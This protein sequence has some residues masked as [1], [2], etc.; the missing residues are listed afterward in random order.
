[1]AEK[2]DI[3]CYHCGDIC[4][5]DSISKEDKY[6]CCNGCL[7]VYELLSQ[8]EMKDYYSMVDIKGLAPKEVKAS[9]FEFLDD[10]KVIES[11]IQYSLAGKSKVI[12]Y[13]PEIYCSACIWLLENLYRLNKGITESEVN[14]LKKELTVVFEE[15]DTGLR[16][17]VELL[18]SIGYRPKLNLSDLDKPKKDIVDR[19]LY[20]KLGIAGFC[21]GNIMLFAF[22]EYLSGGMYD[23]SIKKFI[24]WIN[25][26]L[27][28]PA[29]YAG[30]SYFKSAWAGL[31]ARHI[32]I[33]VP[34]SLGIITLFIRSAYEIISGTGAGFID[35]MSGL[36]FFLLIGKVFQQKTYYNMSFG[37]DYKS[38]FPLSV[39]LKK[40]GG[41]TH[42]SVKNIE[43]G[44]TI[45]IRNNEIIPADSRLLSDSASIDYS[46]VTGESEPVKVISGNKIYAGG[47]HTGTAI[48]LKVLKKFHQSYLTGL[49]N[50]EA[51]TTEKD[52]FISK[53]SDTAAKYFTFAVLIIAFGSFFFHLSTNLDLA[54]NTFTSVLIIACPC[55]IALTVPF[56]YGTA[57]R[58]FGRNGFFLK[59][60]K[61]IE[62]MSR[63]NC[64]VFDKTG[65]LTKVNKSSIEYNGRDLSDTEKSLIA[66]SA[67]NSTHPI[68]RL[69]YDYYKEYDNI[70]ITSFNEIPAKGIEAEYGNSRI[71]IGSRKW[72]F[73]PLTDTK[74][75]G[76]EAPFIPTETGVFLSVNNEIAGWFLVKTEY[77]ENLKDLINDLD[78]DYKLHVLTGDRDTE[79]ENLLSLF[80]NNE[81]L[82]FEQLP[83]DKLNFI[84]EAMAGKNNVMMIGDGLNDAGALRKADI[85]IAVTEDT[86]N[87]TPGSDGIL[88][89]DKLNDLKSYFKLSK[90]SINTVIISYT[91][92]ILYNIAG[93]T[94]A[95]Q[96][97]LEPVVA[98]ILMPLSS[99][100]VVV[101]TVTKVSIDAK[102]LK[103]K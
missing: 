60:D 73:G 64:I 42:V 79:K 95:V 86:A 30:S 83:E 35:S 85:G 40:E 81:S 54:L 21:F 38:Y 76:G 5:D 92:S 89:A 4:P 69:I 8:N 55:A 41:E 12:F 39:I 53:I 7:F 23:E 17:I 94:F 63:I 71:R 58:I 3:I 46:F 72:V 101:F 11:L 97:L 67:K 57:L 62:L 47:R 87:F 103:L 99:L 10:P 13:I 24:G 100:S 93:F 50:K 77:R 45:I 19:G 70:N 22:P 14:F 61:I 25:L 29:L 66:S 44:D 80:G 84:S 6:F 26:I 15:K 59:N 31:K 9:E 65:T 75:V 98:A 91:I 52:S 68:S 36:I 56:T 78:K 102:L 33:D 51:F 43:K 16:Q 32:N 20:I 1:M 27:G 74:A 2:E 49:W 28:F 88:L 96:G 82:H 48:E 90:K 18:T 37:R 34:I